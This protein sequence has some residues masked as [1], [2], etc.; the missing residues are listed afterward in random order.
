MTAPADDRIAAWAA[1]VQPLFRGPFVVST[2]LSFLIFG[3]AVIIA[4]LML[5]PLGR[6]DVALPLAWALALVEAGL[7]VRRRMRLKV[8]FTLGVAVLGPLLIVMTQSLGR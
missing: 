7:H 1:R 8:P 6:I 2:G 3:G 5:I 4:T